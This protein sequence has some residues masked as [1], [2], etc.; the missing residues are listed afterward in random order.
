[1]SQEKLGTQ[2]PLAGLGHSSCPPV[3]AAAAGE[4]TRAQTS[5]RSNTFLAGTE[6]A[7][8][9]QEKRSQRWKGHSEHK[10]DP[11]LCFPHVHAK[12]Y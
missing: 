1:M 3:P 12:T 9:T 8:S 2:D 7:E 10:L 5:Q 6:K 11:I 4:L